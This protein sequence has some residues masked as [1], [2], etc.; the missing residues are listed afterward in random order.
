[1][2]KGLITTTEGLKDA[3]MTNVPMDDIKELNNNTSK[4]MGFKFVYGRTNDN[5]VI[6][7]IKAGNW[8]KR[9]IKLIQEHGVIELIASFCWSP[10]NFEIDGIQT[11]IYKTIECGK[12]T[13]EHFNRWLKAFN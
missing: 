11:T 12:E 6:E 2:F 9:D 10:K 13:K 3:K 4:T 7:F 1:M 8:A 5:K